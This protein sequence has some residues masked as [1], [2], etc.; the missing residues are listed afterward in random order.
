MNN[1]IKGCMD[2]A[3]LNFDPQA[4]K[5]SDV[6]YYP[7]ELTND[8]LYN[9]NLLGAYEQTGN[10]CNTKDGSC[11]SFTSEEKTVSSTESYRTMFLN[12]YP[13]ADKTIKPG[14]IIVQHVLDK[15]KVL[16]GIYVMFKQNNGYF[17]EGGDWEYAALQARWVSKN[18]PNGYLPPDS[19]GMQPR[20][21]IKTCAKCHS[22]AKKDFLFNYY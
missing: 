8:L 2:P 22:R 10:N 20:G 4:T 11:V 14:M 12:T 7:A 3:A 9:A 21:K 19:T 15:N 18:A 13:K 17:P 16:S 5:S 1:D 6:C